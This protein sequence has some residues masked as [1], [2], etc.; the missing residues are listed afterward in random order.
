MRAGRLI[1]SAADIRRKLRA[2]A[3]L[4]ENAGATEEEREVD[5]P[6]AKDC[7]KHAAARKA[8]H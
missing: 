2:L 8:K 1:A 7:A 3:A 4:A 5:E 6:A